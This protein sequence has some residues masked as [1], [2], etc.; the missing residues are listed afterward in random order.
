MDNKKLEKL[1]CLW[2]ENRLLRFVTIID[3]DYS[4]LLMKT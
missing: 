1:M 2:I 4:D 3:V